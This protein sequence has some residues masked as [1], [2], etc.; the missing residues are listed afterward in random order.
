MSRALIEDGQDVL[1]RLSA[2]EAARL[3]PQNADAHNELGRTH[4]RGAGGPASLAAVA[5][6]FSSSVLVDP[7]FAIGR[8]N[9]ELVVRVF[10][11]QATGLLAVCMAPIVW[12]ASQPDWNVRWVSAM[13]FV[14]LGAFSVRF[15][16]GLGQSGRLA[17]HSS[18]RREPLL[19]SS[20]TLAVVTLVCTSAT[21]LPVPP[22]GVLQ[23]TLLGV[24]SVCAFAAMVTAK[25]AGNRVRSKPA[26]ARRP[27]RD[28]EGQNRRH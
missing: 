9:F 23:D 7:R 1:A 28:S 20:L 27:W 13:P 24:A 15:T 2:I 8:K 18:L 12:V 6:Q 4:L 25:L 19:K 14:V 22:R 5:R 26:R 3:D 10:A 21:Y 11:E 17:A 16:H